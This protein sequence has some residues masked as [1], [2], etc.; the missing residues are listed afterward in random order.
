MTQGTLPSVSRARCPTLHISASNFPSP[1]RILS[2]TSQ[3]RYRESPKTVP[4][5]SPTVLR[6]WQGTSAPRTLDHASLFQ[7]LSPSLTPLSLSTL[8]QRHTGGTHWR[9]HDGARHT[10]PRIQ[11]HSICFSITTVSTR[12]SSKC[13]RRPP[14]SP[15]RCK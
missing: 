8:P 5:L 1:R 12:R 11:Q 9:G 6:R 10:L 4:L 15:P 7:F 13:K 3:R 2:K 14:C